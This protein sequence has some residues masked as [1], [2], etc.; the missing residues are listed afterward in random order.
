MQFATLALISRYN[1]YVE[2]K[3]AAA[4]ANGSATVFNLKDSSIELLHEWKE[5]RLRAGQKYVGLDIFQQGIYSCTSNG[6][7]R[8]TVNIEDESPTSQTAVLPMRLSDWRLSSDGSTFA[9]VGDEVELSVCDVEQIFASKSPPGAT[10]SVNGQKRKR[11]NDLLPGEIWRARNVANDSLSLRQ[12]VHNN[13]LTYIAPSPSASQHHLLVGTQF[14]NVRRYDTRSFRRPVA[15]WQKVAKTGG[16]NAVEKGFNEH[17]A[18]VTDQGSSIFSLD[19][20]NG[21]VAYGY[22]GLSGAAT[23]LAPSPTVLASVALDRYA[24]IHSTFPPAESGQQQEHK[25]R[26]LETVFMK[27]TPTVVVWDQDSSNMET[28][29]LN[30]SDDNGEAEDDVW[31][32]ME[33]VQDEGSDAEDDRSKRRELKKARSK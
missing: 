22:K 14:G 2:A 23:S 28:N 26:V 31:D 19:L 9:Y 25:G 21:R 24:R 20:R 15:D 18:L 11:R 17:E 3:V 6:A 32:D 4:H 29:T 7:L 27:S 1:V 16:I 8:R 30:E 12:P 13:C 5:T 10:A 33:S